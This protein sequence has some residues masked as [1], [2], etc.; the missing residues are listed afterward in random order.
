MLSYCLKSR[1]N[2]ESKNPKVA[3]T[4][5]GRIMLL[6]KCE[7]FHCKKL[8]FIKEQKASRLLS[9]LGIK[10]PLSKIPLVGSLFFI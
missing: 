10:T 9:N 4:I 7:V 3:R 6:S 5:N 1:K 2:T 8:K